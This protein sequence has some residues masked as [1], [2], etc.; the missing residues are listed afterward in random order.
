VPFKVETLKVGDKVS[1]TGV[2]YLYKDMYEI[3][4]RM[5]ED[6]KKF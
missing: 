3:L 5:P 4:P 1:V 6:I 2:M